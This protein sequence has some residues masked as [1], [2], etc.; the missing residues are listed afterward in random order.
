MA[1]CAQPGCCGW[2]CSYT[3]ISAAGGF[4]RRRVGSSCSANPVGQALK[5]DYARGF[6]Y[7]DCWVED[8]RLVVLNAMDAASRGAVIAPRTRCVAADRTHDGW[9]LRVQHRGVQQTI[10]ARAVVNAAGP[11]VGDVLAK[12][13]R[14]DTTARVRLVKGSHIVVRR[15]YRGDHCYIFQ[16]ADRRIVFVIPYE[17]DFSL[18]G[19]TDLDYQGDP[20]DVSA[21]QRGSR[22]SVP[23]RQRVPEASGDAGPGR[24]ALCR[25]S[26]AV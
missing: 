17:R 25:C 23:Q 7:S 24:L 2:G 3:T 18:I 12:V 9:A 21:F 16:N 6:E 22:L 4:C 11:W 8:S 19:T 14:A 20:A 1:A 10:H 26:L 13:V 15:L 5:S